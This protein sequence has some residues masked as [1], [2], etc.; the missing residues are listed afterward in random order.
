MRRKTELKKK[1]ALPKWAYL[2]AGYF[3]LALLLVFHFTNYFLKLFEIYPILPNYNAHF[4][5]ETL[6]LLGAPLILIVSFVLSF[7]FKRL[8]GAFLI[9]GSALI[10]AGIAFQSGY[11][12]KIYL[13]KMAIIGLPQ[14]IS[15]IFF[16][17]S[18]K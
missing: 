17:K 6:I 5:Q 16:L 7:K 14:I 13:L 3:F 11:F 15:G 18:G 12:L 8:C 2:A 10:S 9:F 1:T 4:W